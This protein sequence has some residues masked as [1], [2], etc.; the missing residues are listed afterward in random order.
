MWPKGRM[1][2]RVV[3]KT[4]LRPSDENGT[5]LINGV[6]AE[7]GRVHEEVDWGTSR[8]EGVLW[9][10]FEVLSRK[11]GMMLAGAAPARNAKG[12]ANT[13]NPGRGFAPNGATPGVLSPRTPCTQQ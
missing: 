1:S 5:S 10:R 11:F 7:D 13:R 3:Q 8:T 2:G 9:V 4:L 6:H 12:L